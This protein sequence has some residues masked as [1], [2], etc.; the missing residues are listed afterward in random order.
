MKVLYFSS[1]NWNWIKQRPH[2]IAENLSNNGFSVEYFSITP[3]FKQ[4]ISKKRISNTLNVTDSY[5]LPY[6]SKFRLIRMIN[7]FL[8]GILLK[9]NYDII[10]LTSPEQYNYVKSNI[11]KNTKIIYECMDNMPFFYPEDKRHIIEDKEKQLCEN[12]D[13]IIITS[14]YLKN[15][16]IN[17]YN[18]DIRK[19]HVIRNAFND[20]MINFNTEKIKLKSPNL[21]YI[22]TISKWI[23]SD[24]LSYFASKNEKYTIYLI[25]PYE[26]DIKIKLS[27]NKN[28]IFTGKINHE[29][30]GK[31][32]SSGD[33]MI[34]PFVIN[35]LIEGVDPVKLY[36][37]LAFGKEV[38]TSHWKELD[39]FP[40][41]HNSEIYFYDSKNQFDIIVNRLFEKELSNDIDD[42]FILD[43]SWDSRIKVYSEIIRGLYE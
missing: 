32:I 28:I 12:S 20:K 23:D 9:D 41:S 40:E 13:L 36:E 21:V 39:Y 5:V 14:E 1:V 25:G 33:I 8:V 17:N 27:K 30:I 19:M 10:I 15:K 7:R 18:I 42:Q 43:N 38:V 37:Y 24:T 16:F 35:E 11:K 2:F 22:G 31:Y 29:D 26:N 34:I 6:A 4:K 3:L